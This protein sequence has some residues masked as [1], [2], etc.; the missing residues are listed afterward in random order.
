VSLAL[1]RPNTQRRAIACVCAASALFVVAAAVVKAVAAE[2]PII[3]IV[4]FRS[5]V[6][7]LVLWPLLQRQGGWRMLRTRRPWGHAARTLTGFIGM[8][9][10]FYGYAALPL[11]TVTAL[12]FAMPLCLAVLSVPLLGERVGP[13]RAAAVAA[14]L[15]GVLVM[16]RPWQEG[17]PGALPLVPVLVVV[18]GVVAWALAMISIRRMGAAGERNVAIVLWFS[19]GST[20]LAALLSIPVWVTPQPWQLVGLCSVGAI[21]AAAQM[22]MTEGYR[23]GETTL[24]AP[25]EYGA[26]LYSTLLGLAIWGEVPDVWSLL[27]IGILMAAGLVVWRSA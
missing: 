25:F 2:I 4:L 21:S 27:G 13:M 19:L 3:E 17:D 10:S 6:A 18:A 8:A 7:C 9:T 5:L 24:V 22:L 16:L 26:I 23:A 11:A 14:G 20:L 12:N 15:V 1:S